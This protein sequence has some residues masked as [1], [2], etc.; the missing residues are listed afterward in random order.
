MMMHMIRFLV[1]LLLVLIGLA[2]YRHWVT[3]TPEGSD[4][5]SINYHIKVDKTQIKEDVDRVRD[6]LPR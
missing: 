2:L 5:S 1:L 6:L 4:D 3:V